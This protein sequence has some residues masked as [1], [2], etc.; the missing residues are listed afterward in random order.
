M[1]VATK[2]RAKLYRLSNIMPKTTACSAK[3][4]SAISV[5]VM[6][7]NGKTLSRLMENG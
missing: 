6:A 2:K 3:T 5:T 7:T 4:E 1:A